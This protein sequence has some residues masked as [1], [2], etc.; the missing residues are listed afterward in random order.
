MHQPSVSLAFDGS[1]AL[2]APVR[3]NRRAAGARRP[4]LA[5]QFLLANLVV[6]LLSMLVLGSWVG[7]QIEAGVLDH[8]AATEAFFVDSVISPSLQG[9]AANPELDAADIARLDW[10]LDATLRGRRVVTVKVWSPDGHIL[11][12]RS[13]PLIGRQ[14]PVDEDLGDALRGEV[15]ANISDLQDEENE[16]ERQQYSRLM[17]VYAPIRASS[18][19]HI[20]GVTEFYSPP[21]ELFADITA[22]RARS[23][24]VVGLVTAA[25]Y[26]LLA[27]IVK[28]GSD[29]II[30]QEGLLRRQ[31]AE[32]SVLHERIRQAAAR[33]TALNEQ[34]LRRISADLH[35]GPGQT[36]ALALLRLDGLR[37]PPECLVCGP[38][39]AD[40]DVV[41]AAVR[42]ALAEVR[43]I[44]ASLRTPELERLSVAEVAERTIT[45]HQRRTGAHVALWTE[46]LPARVPLAIKIAVLRT[47]QEALSNA[48]RHGGA[49]VEMAVRLHGLG[50]TLHLTVTDHGCGFVV[51]HADQSGGMGLVV[52]RERAELLGGAFEIRSQPGQGTVIQAYWPLTQH[53]EAW[54]S[55]SVSS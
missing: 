44:T 52:M 32:L 50:E 29:T 46:T 34:A 22:A 31:F 10:L 7:Q 8:A 38:T 36:L 42:D 19:G 54:L 51:E 3:S 21:D 55:P 48:T 4:T 25:A 17:Q 15:N 53:E 13:R 9:L 11:Y 14:Y 23:W 30:R 37:T 28:R 45:T 43:T 18:D 47:L 33:T 39:S 27:G 16:L 24:L 20:I 1:D 49:G 6:L 5:V 40:H 26:L 41:V 12:S 2:E 35:D